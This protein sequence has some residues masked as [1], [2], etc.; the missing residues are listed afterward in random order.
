MSVTLTLVVCTYFFVVSFAL[1]Q[2]RTWG[3]L[4]FYLDFLFFFEISV[5]KFVVVGLE[6]GSFSLRFLTPFNIQPV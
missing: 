5:H 2:Q 1:L 4:D 3:F 6:F